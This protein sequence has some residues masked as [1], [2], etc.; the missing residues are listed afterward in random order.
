MITMLFEK[1]SGAIIYM[2][3][4]SNGVEFLLLHYT[5]GHWDFP[6]GN[7][8]VGE[9][10]LMAARREVFEETGIADVEFLEG[11]RRT[12]QYYYRR[13]EKLVQKEVVF[14][15]SN[16]NRREILLSSEHIGFAW[17]NYDK[18]IS[19]LTFKSAK[20]LLLEAKEFLESNGI[21]S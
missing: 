16:T 10:E 20:N 5:S 7:I 2:T 13:D 3:R 19:L 1:S 4:E 12:I 8:E 6:K 11:F 9:D 18:A 21:N 14:R 15:I 17:K